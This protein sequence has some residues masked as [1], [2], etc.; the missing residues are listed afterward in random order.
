[1]GVYVDSMRASFGRMIMCHMVADTHEELVGMTDKIGVA[2]KWIQKPGQPF[3]H[4]DICLSKRGKAVRLG[5]KEV[6][7]K[8]L[9]VWL[10]ERRGAARSSLG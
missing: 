6:G 4:F 7:W 9:S 2:R 10:R 1:M 3:E 8:E 5:A